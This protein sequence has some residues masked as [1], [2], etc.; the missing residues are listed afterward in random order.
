M[1]F[2]NY[3]FSEQY[4]PVTWM[5]LAWE[6]VFQGRQLEI[7]TH[8]RLFLLSM[9]GFFTYLVMRRVNLT[10]LPAAFGG[11]IYIFNFRTLD[12]FRYANALD[13]I[14]WL[15]VLIYL[16]DRIITTPRLRFALLYAL[17]QYLLL[18]PGHM[19]EALY[20]LYF[21]NLYLVVR[22][23]ML[24]PR[25]NISSALRWLASRLAC[26]GG[27]QALG[28]GLCAVM[29]VP[30]FKDTLRLLA[31]RNSSDPSFY[32][33]WGLTWREGVYNLFYPWLG[34][35]HSEFYSQQLVWIL[36][37][38]AA[39]SLFRKRPQ[40]PQPDFRMLIFFFIVL[41]VGI[42]YSLG[43]RTPLSA[44]IDATVPFLTKFRAHGRVMSVGMFAMAGIAAFGINQIV[45]NIQAGVKSAS[46]LVIGFV[47]FLL[48]GL[49]LAVGTAGGWI[50]LSESR[51]VLPLLWNLSKHSPAR[52]LHDPSM[53]WTLAQVIIAVALVNLV[54]VIWCRY[55]RSSGVS[56]ALALIVVG[57]VEVGI[58]HRRGTWIIE[59]RVESAHSKQFEDVDT[60]HT[61]TFRQ[62]PFFMY[63]HDS[64]PL[65]GPK[66]ALPPYQNVT[67]GRVWRFL[68]KGG[69]PAWRIYYQ[70][71]RGHEIPR[72][73]V[74]SGVRLVEGNDLSAIAA[75]NPYHTS[76]ID[77]TDPAN[78]HARSDESLVQ[79]S[80]VTKPQEGADV[81]SQFETLNIDLEVEVYTFNR[82][83]FSV[84]TAT[85][86]L[87]S[88][89]DAYAKGWQATID[90][91][92]TP[93]YRSNHVF[94]A[95]VLPPGHHRVEFVYDPPSF[96]IGLLIS[97]ASSCV[98][99]ALGASCLVTI[100]RHRILLASL[101]LGLASVG[102]GQVHSRVHEMARQEGRINYDPNQPRAVVP[103][104]ATAP[105]QTITTQ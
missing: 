46:I 43:P 98:L 20:C 47:I 2:A 14:V 94:K 64:I 103:D 52:I 33:Q 15:P 93:I 28:F 62:Q 65:F 1:P 60:Y 50:E 97:L 34:D 17:V 78:A 31:V 49:I 10:A 25:T 36:V 21:A 42:L 68:T 101:A 75:M 12:T 19:Q 83:S 92:P 85:G 67:P 66:R 16:L 54:V 74:T 45:H 84:R 3:F 26:W 95:I 76:I 39:M 81:R 105:E 53:V 87:F 13:V 86:G 5:M 59:D 44:I 99:L 63:F 58:Y 82:A 73:Y 11:I 96:R 40:S 48:A 6:P 38:V 9:A 23:L 51:I 100:P 8:L 22:M 77:M 104:Y 91:E 4:S 90:D 88:Y 18:V 32:H 55:R 79:L 69:A 24:V 70:N 41:I 7:L 27:G 80:Q 72:A 57:L 29:L 37:V 102:A 61:R 71:V 89:S 56:L 35:V 30:I